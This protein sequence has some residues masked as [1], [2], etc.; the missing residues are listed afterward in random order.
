MLLDFLSIT[1][2]VRRKLMYSEVSVKTICQNN[3]LSATDSYNFDPTIIW[4][5]NITK[6]NGQNSGP[7]GTGFDEPPSG[8]TAGL[9]FPSKKDDPGYVVRVVAY[10]SSTT[11][12]RL[13]F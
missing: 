4:D 7:G 5:I 8:A 9:V 10:D 12:V 2:A 1:M 3:V 6:P 11:Q 13:Y